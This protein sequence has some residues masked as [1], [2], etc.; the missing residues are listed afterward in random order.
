THRSTLAATFR[1]DDAAPHLRAFLA[2]L[3]PPIADAAL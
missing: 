2:C 3:P 1:T